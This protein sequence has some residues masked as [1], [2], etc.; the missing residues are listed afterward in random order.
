M[1]TPVWPAS[2]PQNPQLMGFQESG[3]GATVRTQMDAGPA[4]VRRRFTIE[5]R[6]I[7]LA[8][9]MTTAQVATFDTFWTSTISYGALAFDWVDFRTLAAQ[10]YR[11]ASRPAYTAL[12]NGYWRVEFMLETVP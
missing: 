2:L 11:I 5:V 12:G 4:K 6:N 3:A 9:V 8:L 1:T 7:S 10:T